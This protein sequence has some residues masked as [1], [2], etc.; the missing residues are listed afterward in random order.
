MPGGRNPIPLTAEVTSDAV[1]VK[2]AD[3]TAGRHW[4]EPK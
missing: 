4:F 3:V 1:I 2:E